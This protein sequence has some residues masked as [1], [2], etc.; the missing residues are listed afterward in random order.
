[1][2]NL[3]ILINPPNSDVIYNELKVVHS[4]PI[5]HYVWA[6]Y[7]H[8][9][10]LSLASRLKCIEGI[11]PVYFDGGVCNLSFIVDFIKQN[12]GEILVVAVSVLSATYQAGL[13][14][15]EKTKEI[16]S[17]IITIFG[18]DHFSA[19]ADICLKKRSKLIDYG[20]IGNEV[21]TG[22]TNLVYDL[23]H[24]IKQAG[25]VY[26]G[27]VFYSHNELFYGKPFNEPIFTDI[28]YNLIDKYFNHT[29]KYNINFQKQV[30][31]T[32]KSVFGKNVTKATAIEIAR[33]CIKFKNNDAC[34]FCS[35]QYS[36]LWRN[37]VS[38]YKIAWEVIY[39]AILLGYDYLYITADELVFTFRSLISNMANNQPDWF[40]NLPEVKRPVI[41]VYARADSLMDLDLLQKLYSIGIR[42]IRVG[43]D[44]LTPLSLAAIRK[45]VNFNKTSCQKIIRISEKLLDINKTVFKN[46]NETGIKLQVGF[47]LGHIG[48]TKEQLLSNYE[49]FCCFLEEG[50]HSI[51]AAD[52]EILSPEPGS[53][54]FRYIT[55][56]DLAETT[57][58]QLNV[59]IASRKLREIIASKWRNEDIID[60][61]EI[62]ED[63][64]QCFMPEIST[65]LLLEIR[66]KM[67]KH[68]KDIGIYIG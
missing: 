15:A 50:I 63:Y 22:F 34:S 40:Q 42:V 39:E 49:Q 13:L 55:D 37:S 36:G 35:I 62:G 14:I 21:L 23:F 67:R 18:N 30:T 28:D 2:R 53:M 19:R 64:I 48:L 16:D 20:F 25:Q 45:P 46:V 8:L 59:T 57:A 7:P 29:E 54:E 6:N 51:I 61:N 5:E 17:A 33:G 58:K 68:C 47:V 66:N 52:I 12:R 43:F 27:I 41:T 32:I 26:P 4:N 9:G 3:V 38:S 60:R 10:I 65:S 56:T 31:N 11:E 24:N 1:M 44:G